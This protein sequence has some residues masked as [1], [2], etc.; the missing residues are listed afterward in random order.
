MSNISLPILATI[1]TEEILPREVVVN[2]WGVYL[3]TWVLDVFDDGKGSYFRIYL[4]RKNGIWASVSQ[5]SG[6]TWGY[7]CPLWDGDFKFATIEDAL[8][9]AWKD[10]ERVEEHF[11]EKPKFYQKAIQF[12]KDFMALPYDKKILQLRI[13]D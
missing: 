6:R 10:F 5:A 1:L 3:H 9:D 7:A 13:R 2:S 4:C 11:R 8:L 12:F